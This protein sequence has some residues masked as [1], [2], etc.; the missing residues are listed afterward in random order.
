RV[1]AGD[2]LGETSGHTE[3]FVAEAGET[4]MVLDIYME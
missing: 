1:S 4:P 3:G 2:P